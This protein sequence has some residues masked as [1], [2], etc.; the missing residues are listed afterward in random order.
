MF[1]CNLKIKGIVESCSDIFIQNFKRIFISEK[2]PS[3]TIKQDFRLL[4]KSKSNLFCVPKT[5]TI[6]SLFSIFFLQYSA[7]I[8]PVHKT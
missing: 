5:F 1:G 6:V 8:F 2:Y 7:V 3:G 4:F